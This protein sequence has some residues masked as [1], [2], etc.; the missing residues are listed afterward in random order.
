VNPKNLDVILMRLDQQD[1]GRAEGDARMDALTKTVTEVRD[2]VLVLTERV[3]VNRC[4][5]PGTC[6]RLAGEVEPLREEVKRINLTMAWMKGAWWG[7]AG[8]AG[9][10]ASSVTFAAV[11]LVE[12]IK[13]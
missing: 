3:E 5:A 4:A 7:I 2:L 9:I 11:Y 6:I 1:K 8:T 12:W 10:V 13:K